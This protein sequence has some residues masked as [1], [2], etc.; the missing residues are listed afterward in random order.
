VGAPV[1]TIRTRLFYARRE[2]QA[3][4]A[5]EPVLEFLTVASP[6]TSESEEEAP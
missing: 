6:E 4:L 1:L 3:M 2:L 5:E